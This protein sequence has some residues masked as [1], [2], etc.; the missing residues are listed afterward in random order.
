MDNRRLFLAA[1]LSLGVIVVWQV[2]FPPPP[3]VSRQVE[4]GAAVAA[5]MVDQ[6]QVIHYAVSL[7]HHR[8][9]NYEFGS[10]FC[11][12]NGLSRRGNQHHAYT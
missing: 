3:P 5:R 8:R 4:D 6:L 9:G 2:F 11:G 10:H 12:R 7:G 1:L